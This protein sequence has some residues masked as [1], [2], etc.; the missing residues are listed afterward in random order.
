[1]VPPSYVYQEFP[2]QV[3][4]RVVYSRAEETA[5]LGQ[6]ARLMALLGHR[7]PSRR[8][9]S[10]VPCNQS[11][12]T[13]DPHAPAQAQQTVPHTRPSAGAL[14]M[15]CSRE[16]RRKGLHMV[17][18]EV[19]DTEIDALIIYKFLAPEDRGNPSAIARALGLLLDGLRPESWRLATRPYDAR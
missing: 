13:S 5:L 8:E 12:G 16:R 14:R 15:R 6:R 9:G 3:F 11:S 4:G 1:M 18:L 19:R 17:R 7:A 2:K 10:H